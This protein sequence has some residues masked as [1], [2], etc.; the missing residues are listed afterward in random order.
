MSMYILKSTIFLVCLTYFESIIRWIE[1]TIRTRFNWYY[2]RNRCD[3]IHHSSD[4]TMYIIDHKSSEKTPKEKVSK[5]DED[6]FK[7][8]WSIYTARFITIF[9]NSVYLIHLF[10]LCCFQICFYSKM[11][12]TFINSTLFHFLR[13]NMAYTN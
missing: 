10:N 4:R 12:Y 2:Y 11:F 6:L 1:S 5:N 9:F 7:T 3:C 13:Q 8:F